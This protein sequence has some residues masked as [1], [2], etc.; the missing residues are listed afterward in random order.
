VSARAPSVRTELEPQAT[1]PALAPSEEVVD[2]L[3]EAQRF[4]PST[5]VALL[6]ASLAL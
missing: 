6:D 4:S 5:F 3:G 1:R 2:V